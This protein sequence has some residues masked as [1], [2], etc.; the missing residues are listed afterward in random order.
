MTFVLIVIRVLVVLL[1]VRLVLRL[2]ASARV[3]YHSVPPR[4]PR[5]VVERKGGTLVRDPN[6]GTYIPESRAIT[7]GTGSH[8]LHF[9]S[10]ACRDAYAAAHRGHVSGTTGRAS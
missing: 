10:A 9:C 1:I 8:A 3:G 7:T 6:C 5:P 4:P 2:I